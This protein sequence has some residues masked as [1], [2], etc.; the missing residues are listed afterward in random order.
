MGYVFIIFGFFVMFSN[1]VELIS[2][3]FEVLTFILDSI[4]S[5]CLLGFGFILTNIYKIQRIIQEN[6]KQKQPEEQA[7][8]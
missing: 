5:T 2:G 3:K 8:E 1:L 4:F 6:K 7:Q